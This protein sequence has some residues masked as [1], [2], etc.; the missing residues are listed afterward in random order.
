[1]SKKSLKQATVK[2][3]AKMI[4][5]LL[6]HGCDLANAEDVVRFLNT[7]IWRARAKTQT[8]LQGPCIW[9]SGT[10]DIAIDSYRDYLN[11]LGLTEVKLPHIRREEKLP[12]FL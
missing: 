9:A 4:K 7:C 8:V 12:S 5:S 2:R 1:M 6:K 3:K 10:K 11:M